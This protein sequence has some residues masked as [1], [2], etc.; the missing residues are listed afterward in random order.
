MKTVVSLLLSLLAV[1]LPAH[2]I[3]D[4]YMCGDIP[5][6]MYRDMDKEYLIREYC[7]LEEM[8]NIY[9]NDIEEKM[10]CGKQQI[11]VGG[12]LTQSRRVTRVLAFHHSC[13]PDPTR[14]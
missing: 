11:L 8:K 6:E 4:I 14:Y 5:Y 2:A 13:S 7:D 3:K 12:V 10:H 1:A 9:K